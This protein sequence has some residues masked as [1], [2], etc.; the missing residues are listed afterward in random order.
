ML[1][2]LA[3]LVKMFGRNVHGAVKPCD[4]PAVK[5]KTGEHILVAQWGKELVF[6]DESFAVKDDLTAIVESQLQQVVAH[7]TGSGDPFQSVSLFHTLSA[8]PCA[9][10][11]FLGSK[12]TFFFQLF[13]IFLQKYSIRHGAHRLYV[14]YYGVL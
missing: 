10:R 4:R 12:F 2:G 6:V 8:R 5:S 14:Y 7:D 9:D 1:C 11:A 3:Q 13:S